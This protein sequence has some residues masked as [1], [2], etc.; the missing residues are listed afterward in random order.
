MKRLVK[1]HNTGDIRYLLHDYESNYNKAKLINIYHDIMQEYDELT[2]T[3]N[4][5]KFFQDIDTEL[6]DSHLLSVIGIAQQCL[7]VLDPETLKPNTEQ[8]Q[9]LINEFNLRLDGRKIEVNESNLV[10][11]DEKLERLW[12]VVDGRMKI[13]KIREEE[14]KKKEKKTISWEKM[15][16][17]IHANLKILP[18]DNCTVTQ[19]LA[20]ESLSTELIRERNAKE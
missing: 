3:D 12:R 6:W 19:Y 20:Y 18:D 14:G 17:K 7:R 2:A 15:R 10:E 16:V 9:L 5:S 4:Y 11:A 8:A 13:K 1:I